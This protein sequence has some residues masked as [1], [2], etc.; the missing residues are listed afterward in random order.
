[1]SR[2][3]ALACLTVGLIAWI[4]GSVYWLM[5][6]WAMSLDVALVFVFGWI[7]VCVAAV[8]DEA[9]RQFRAKGRGTHA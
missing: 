2:V 7:A 5:D 9:R 1:M 4:A 8:Y 6:A 3:P